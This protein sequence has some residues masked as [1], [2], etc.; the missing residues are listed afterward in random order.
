MATAVI[1]VSY[2]LDSGTPVTDSTTI[3]DEVGVTLDC[4]GSGAVTDELHNIAIDVSELSSIMMLASANMT[5]ETNSSSAPDNTYT[6]LANIPLIWQQSSGIT[7]PVTTDVTK[8][9]ITKAGAGSWTFKLR[10]TQ[11]GSP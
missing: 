3:T 2:T 9:Y 8:I 10:C 5:I 11:D 6:L 1:T 7:N 4:E